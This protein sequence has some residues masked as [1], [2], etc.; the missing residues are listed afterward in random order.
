M[1]KIIT[2]WTENNKAVVYINVDRKLTRCYYPD[3]A[4]LMRLSKIVY[5]RSLQGIGTVRPYLAGSPGYVYEL[6]TG[7]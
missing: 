7:E 3:E 2:V 6:S 1:K 5:S 4:R